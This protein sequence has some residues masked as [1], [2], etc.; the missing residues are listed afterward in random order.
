M[1]KGYY[2]GP[3]HVTPVNVFTVCIVIASLTLVIIAIASPQ[4]FHQPIST[5]ERHVT[6]EDG[7]SL[8]LGH[9]RDMTLEVNETEAAI[10]AAKRDIDLRSTGTV[11]LSGNQ[12][13][14][15]SKTFDVGDSDQLV[16][17]TMK[18]QTPEA[19]LVLDAESD[20]IYLPKVIEHAPL[21]TVTEIS[22]STSVTYTPAQLHGFI[23]RSGLPSLLADKLPTAADLVDANPRCKAGH[24][25]SFILHNN[26]GT[27]PLVVQGG[28]GGTQ[29][30]GLVNIPAGTATTVHIRF[31]NVA[32]GSEAYHW[33]HG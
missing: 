19:S 29:M 4:L 7:V 12:I 6:L 11:Q 13:R 18:T 1:R 26:S 14:V 32:Q 15:T 25:L 10:R 5:F 21:P 9:D 22:A 28:T 8:F 3:F 20:T 17:V 30:L 31:S 24:M 23:V 2:I 16:H 33:W 27:Y